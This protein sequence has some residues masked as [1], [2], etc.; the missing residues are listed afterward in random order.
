MD[1]RNYATTGSLILLTATAF[2]MRVIALKH[3][4]MMNNDGPVYIHQ[5][6]ALYHGFWQAIGSC[7]V[8]YPTV[9][10]VL[11]AVFYRFSGD[12]VQSAMTANLMFGTLMI[13]PL[14]LFLRKFTDEQTS[15]LTGF[16]FAI[17]PLFVIQSVNVIRDPSYWFFC[18]LGLYLLVCNNENKKLYALAWSSLS[19]IAA[20]ATRIE[21]MIFLIGGLFYCFTIFKGKRLKA[22]T[23]FLAPV[24]LS[25]AFF[26]LFQFMNNP[27]NFYQHRF[28]DILFYM[29]QAL[30][31]YRDLR[32]AM[33][34]VIANVEHENLIYFLQNS[35]TLM[36]F[37][38][39]GAIL[40]SALEAYFYVFSLLMICGLIGLKDKIKNDKRLLTLMVIA[41]LN[42][43]ILYIYC[44][45]YW[46]VEGR[47]LAPLIII[48]SVFMG[49]GTERIIRWI[50]NKSG[51]SGFIVVILL[52]MLFFAI[53]LP[54][55]LK[56]QEGDKLVFKEIG[57]TIA[58]LDGRQDAIELISLG[59][60]RWVHFYANLHTKEPICPDKYSYWYGDKTIIGD[61]YGDFIKN[62]KTRKIRYV[63]WQENFWPKN[64][65]AFLENVRDNDLM[66]IQEWHH[67][68]TG[69][70]I[71][72]K[73]HSEK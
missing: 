70:I 34:S 39:L 43:V 30:E 20:T 68:D 55:N 66:K 13:I 17:L 5:A 64:K 58:G 15:F 29:T 50:R 1:K 2:I 16:V 73:V 48:T 42:I 33:V 67:R 47:R 51:L 4:L 61:T 9:Y 32:K 46:S 36:W 7:T 52:C 65:F 27:G 12:W 28:D 24:F 57:E 41:V 63:V 60:Q 22:V 25:A 44:L 62:M 56:I 49:F 8:D 11:I 53:T 72:Y 26:V 54:K 10:T 18:V 71:L 21:G 23:L 6:R 38:A 31:Q 40:H 3:T 14:Y 45:N 69:K 59:G 19:F 35:R 37:T